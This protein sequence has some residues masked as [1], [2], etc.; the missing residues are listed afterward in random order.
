MAELPDPNVHNG[1]DV[2]AP[3]A[4]ADM[5]AQF[6]P[7][8]ALPHPLVTHTASPAQWRRQITGMPPLLGSDWRDPEGT[9]NGTEA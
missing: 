6:G 8:P 5:Q 9:M 7:I 3:G 2:P 1:A 4:L